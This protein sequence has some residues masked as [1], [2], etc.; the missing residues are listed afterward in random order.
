MG[1]ISLV[2]AAMFVSNI[3]LG[4]FWGICP[5]LGV[6]KSHKSAIGMTGALTFVVL[7][8]SI[9]CWGLNKLLV[10]LGVEY[11][12]IVVFVLVIASFV[13]FLEFF[14]KKYM[15]GLYKALGIYL[16]LITTNCVVL[17]VA[18]DV[19]ATTTIFS[20]VNIVVGSNIGYV[21]GYALAVSL[22]YGLVL[23]VFSI[24]R[25]RL[26]SQADSPKAFKGTAIAL[27]TACLMALAFQGFAGM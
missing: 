8:S 1:F 14:M 27:I 12:Q 9:I 23:I 7:C 5:F 6:S 15:K 10:A 26:D 19:A 18:K 2:I 21:I 13:Q 24:I 20:N 17:T 25:E 16:P 4:R 22:G 11:L 3:I